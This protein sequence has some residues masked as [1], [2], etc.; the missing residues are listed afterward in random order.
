M[1]RSTLFLS[2]LATAALMGVSSIPTAHPTVTVLD[3]TFLDTPFL[4]SPEATATLALS[5][6]SDVLLSESDVLNVANLS[7]P[8][9]RPHAVTDD[10]IDHAVEEMMASRNI[11]GLSLAV[12]Q[13][14]KLVKAQGYG[15]LHLDQQVRTSPSSVFPIASV[16]KPFTA[17]GIMLLVQDGLIELDAPISSYLA[18]T[19]EQWKNI[20]V[21]QILAHTAGLSE[22]VYESNLRTL[23]TPSKFL[24]KAGELPLDF[25]PGD[26]WMYSNT[27]YNLA[28]MMISEV[29]DQP[30]AEFM[31]TRIFAPLGM[32]HTDV[33]R[34][35]YNFSNRAT[36]YWTPEDQ[37]EPYPLD[38]LNPDLVPIVYGSGSMTST[39]LDL[40]R[41]DMAL[42]NEQLLAAETQ[43]E[44]YQPVTMNSGRRFNYGIG[45]F[46]D[47]INGHQTIAHGGNI[48]GFTSSFSRFVDGELTVIVL[49]NKDNAG[50]DIALRIAEQYIP[51]LVFD[52]E[53]IALADPNPALTEQL[54]RYVNGDEQAIAQTSEWQILLSTPRGRAAWEAFRHSTHDTDFE[55]LELLQAIDDL[56]G[57]RYRYRGIASTTQPIMEFVV[58]P[59]GSLMTFRVDFEEDN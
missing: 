18:N 20:T 5:S 48:P 6:E 15:F 58:T 10:V 12:V 32:N 2:G 50:D 53:A 49:T 30:F 38:V 9:N 36:G 22:G 3:T 43:D 29:S 28:A 45:W 39:V 41:W 27:G 37:L 4:N 7:E 16:S 51:E 40:A 42:Q 57:T 56:N 24:S 17:M 34:E 44:M 26:A 8:V 14:G 31:E 55:T 21:R 35:D 25:E 1:K 59:D 52:K 19:P 23:T 13:D 54:L 33:I 11:P 47:R 46:L